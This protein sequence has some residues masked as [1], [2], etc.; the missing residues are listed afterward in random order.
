MKKLA[1]VAVAGAVGLMGLVGMGTMIESAN[2]GPESLYTSS[3]TVMDSSGTARVIAPFDIEGICEKMKMPDN[4]GLSEYDGAICQ[5]KL[6]ETAE[7]LGG[8]YGVEGYNDPFVVNQV[9]P[10]CKNL[11]K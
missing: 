3:V 5:E 4:S 6:K 9:M 7:W 11:K 2:E 10:T 8:L 1:K